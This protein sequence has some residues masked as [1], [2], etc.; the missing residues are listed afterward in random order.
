VSVAKFLEREFYQ[1]LV[2]GGTLEGV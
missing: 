1:S 2:E